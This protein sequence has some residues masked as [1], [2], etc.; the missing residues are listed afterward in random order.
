MALNLDSYN[1]EVKQWDTESNQDIR[2]RASSL[3]VMHRANSPSPSSSIAKLKSRQ[4]MQDGAIVRISK[5]FPRELIWAHKGAGKGRGGFKG[6]RW[7]DKYGNAQKT[8]PESL[9]KMGTEGRVAKPFFNES[10]DGP[11]GVDKLATIAA[12]KLGDSLVGSMFI[13]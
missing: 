3:G 6:S 13:K 2:S 9:G 4:Y 11:N 5:I 1:E 12:E 7:V 8:N 10:L